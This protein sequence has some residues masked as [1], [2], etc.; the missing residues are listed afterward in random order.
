M[1][2]I[3]AVISGK[4]GTGKTSLCA[5][6][7]ACLGAEGHRVLVVDGDVG[8]R[9]LDISLGLTQEAVIPFT[10]VMDGEADFSQ[11][12]T[13]PDLPNV[14]LLTAP[15]TVEPQDLDVEQFA[16][17]MER[18]KEEFDW[19]LMDAP[20]GVGP[21]FR[22]ITAVADQAIV[23]TGSDPASLRDGTRATDLAQLAGIPTISLVVN[24]VNKRLLST[25]SRTVD[26]MMDE[27]GLPLLGIVPDDVNVTLAAARQTPLILQ[28][29]RGAAAACLRI[30]RRLC[31][32]RVSLKY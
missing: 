30:A 5:G 26:D 29:N 28:T 32:K 18:A 10:A 9:N 6:L 4:G 3:L 20:A 14:T 23:V 22:M 8:M 31:G 7:A 21:G 1:G 2:Q 25:I 19:C 11:G 16:T 27:V 12:A 24:R 15:T 13:R 17:M